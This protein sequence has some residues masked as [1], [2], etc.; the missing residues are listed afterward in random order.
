M[1]ERAEKI[2]L[3]RR[4]Q[5]L[6]ELERK[7]RKAGR[8]RHRVRGGIGPS[9]ES[10][11]LIFARNH[12]WHLQFRE[13]VLRESGPP[14]HHCSQCGGFGEDWDEETKTYLKPVRHSDRCVLGATPPHVYAGT[15][16]TG[17]G[18]GPVERLP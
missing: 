18:P 12:E 10:K 11:D 16:F 6:Q 5:S 13:R 15:M 9:E 14:T 3:A 1:M 17:A 2:A 8:R 4:Q 7:A